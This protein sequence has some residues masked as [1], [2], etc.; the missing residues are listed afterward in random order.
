MPELKTET[1]G[2]GIGGLALAAAC[3]I[4]APQYVEQAQQEKMVS[5]AKCIEATSD[6]KLVDGKEMTIPSGYK[7]NPLIYTTPDMEFEVIVR[8]V[9]TDSTLFIG[10]FKSDVTSLLDVNVNLQP[11]ENPEAKKE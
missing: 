11:S 10:K 6:V 9:D 4:F 1:I 7:F 5:E 2:T 3:A 8:R